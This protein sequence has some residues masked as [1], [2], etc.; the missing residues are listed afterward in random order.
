MRHL[1]ESGADPRT[2][3]D[4][5]DVVR[6]FGATGELQPARAGRPRGVDLVVLEV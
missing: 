3:E 5:L 1:L 2:A 4:L 6:G